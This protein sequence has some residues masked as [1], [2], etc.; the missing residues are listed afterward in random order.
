MLSAIA[1]A[2]E[3][4]PG[5]TVQ[6]IYSTAMGGFDFTSFIE[7]LQ[8]TSVLDLQ[9]E[10]DV[11]VLNNHKANL[12]AGTE[13]PIREIDAGSISSGATAAKATTAVKQ[14]GV[15]LEITPQ[16][17]NNHQVVMHVHL[18]NSDVQNIGTD[19][20]AFPKQSFDGDL[21]AA[22]GETA[23]LGGLTQTS[24]TSTRSGIP[25]LIDLPI[26]GRLFGVTQHTETKRDLLLLITPHIYD[27]GQ[28]T[29]AP[30]G[31]GT[32]PDRP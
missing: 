3:R 1:N 21:I 10:P 14:V 5:A 6:L 15:I 24:V 26:I 17:T 27:E 19:A 20:L 7:A 31:G 32:H 18:E 23:V 8:Q 25:F 12:T 11:T 29:V 9:G 30:P 28:Q 2:T 22:D 16:I 13:V 4:V